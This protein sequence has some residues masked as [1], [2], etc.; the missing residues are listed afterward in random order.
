M[1][2]RSWGAM[3]VIYKGFLI[4]NTNGLF[5]P[6]QGIMIMTDVS[7]ESLRIWVVTYRTFLFSVFFFFLLEYSYFTILCQFLT[8]DKVNQLYVYIHPLFFEFPSHLC[9][10]RA[11]SSLCY[12]VDTHQLSILYK[13]FLL[14]FFCERKLQ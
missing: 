2:N 13:S 6:L 8:Y 9:Q 11:L 14:H 5:F 4:G 10:H 3:A 7:P 1:S 12:T